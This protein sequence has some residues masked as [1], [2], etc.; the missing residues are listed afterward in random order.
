MPV[1]ILAL[2]QRSGIPARFTK[3]LAW[4]LFALI[5]AG[6]LWLAV[7]AFRGWVADGKEQAVAVDRS[8]VTIEAANLVINATS[9]ATANQMARDD[10]FQNDQEE[11][12]HEADTKSDASSVGPGVTSVLDRM[13]EQQAAGRRGANAAR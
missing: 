3:V 4:L 9:A 1:F 7:A 13:R 11:L 12:R 5:V 6:L 2:L 8:D 10:A